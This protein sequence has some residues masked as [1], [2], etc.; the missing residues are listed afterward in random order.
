MVI[1]GNWF[2]MIF[3]ALAQKY[4]K[5]EFVWSNLPMVCAPIRATM[6]LASGSPS[7]SVWIWF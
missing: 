7:P 5:R 3:T 1:Y 4:L 2:E 6:A